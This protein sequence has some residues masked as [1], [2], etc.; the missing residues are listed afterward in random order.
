MPVAGRGSCSFVPLRRVWRAEAMTGE[1]DIM[2][3]NPNTGRDHTTI[4]RSI[5]GPVSAAILAARGEG[6]LPNAQ[7]CDAVANMSVSGTDM[8]RTARQDGRE[9]ES[10]RP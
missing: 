6:S 7:L 5:Y 8:F 3:K 10:R 2:T 4:K 1:I 9:Q